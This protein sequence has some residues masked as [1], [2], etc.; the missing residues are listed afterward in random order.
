MAFGVP[1][2]F[3]VRKVPVAEAFHLLRMPALNTVVCIKIKHVGLGWSLVIEVISPEQILG[4][5]S[6]EHCKN[7]KKNY[8]SFSPSYIHVP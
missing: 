2:K 3:I 8:T 7:K 4:F 6:Q 1:I 5:I